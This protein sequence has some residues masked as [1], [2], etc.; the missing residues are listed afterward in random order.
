M[1]N[2]KHVLNRSYTKDETTTTVYYHESHIEFF[3]EGIMC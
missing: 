3:R 2:R 1:A